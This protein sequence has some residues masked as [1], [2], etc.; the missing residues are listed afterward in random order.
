MCL[1]DAFREVQ[2]REAARGAAFS[3][4]KNKA[5]LRQLTHGK[6]VSTV[7]LRLLPPLL[8]SGFRLRW[9]RVGADLHLSW[10]VAADLRRERVYRL[11]FA[12]QARSRF[13][14]AP[15]PPLPPMDGPEAWPPLSPDF[16]ATAME[17]AAARAAAEAPPETVTLLAA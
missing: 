11:L 10:F 14:L 4:S 1:A 3:L 13:K 6:R 2:H 7:L 17:A 16:D 15:L 9:R 5:E 12:Q 8:G